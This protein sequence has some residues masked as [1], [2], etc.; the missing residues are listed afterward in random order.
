MVTSTLFVGFL[1]VVHP[2]YERWGATDEEVS[3]TLPG[4][5]VLGRTARQET[6]ATTIDAP[7][8]SVWPWLAQL[9]QDRGGFYSFRILEDLVG[10]EMP[11]ADRILPEKQEWKPGDR[12]WMYP[13]HKLGGAGSAPLRGLVPGRALVFGT[14]QLGTSREG[15]NDGSWAFVLEPAGDG[16]A[17]R[18]LVRGRALASPGIGAAVFD[19]LVFEPIHFV[20]EKKM[21]RELAARAEGRGPTAVRDAS[22]VV[23]WTVTF[24]V[25]FTAFVLSLRRSSYGRSLGVMFAAGLAFQLLTFGQPGAIAASVVASLLLLAL[26][27]DK[28]GTQPLETRPGVP[29]PSR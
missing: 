17:T 19:R 20:M 18:L 12:L 13:P 1:F 21:M 10:C 6:R 16:R 3:R 9:G 7:I 24:V 11:D 27:G 28:I 29:A 23:A 14:W 25:F 15:P 2:W 26:V 4:D 22:E 5:E 8:E